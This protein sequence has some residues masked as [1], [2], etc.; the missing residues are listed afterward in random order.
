MLTGSAV[1][2]P[3]VADAENANSLVVK[4]E[5]NPVVAYSK[6][7]LGRI[8]AFELFHVARACFGEALDG[9]LDPAGD[10]LFEPFHVIQGELGPLDS[11]HSSLVTLIPSGAW[12]PHAGYPCRR[13]V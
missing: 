3:A 8:N 1:G 11:L 4:V 9:L 13:S 6:A 10:T 12:L 5:A 2:L 7:L